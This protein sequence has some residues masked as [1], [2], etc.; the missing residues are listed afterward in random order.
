MIMIVIY[1]FMLLLITFA[2]LALINHYNY[3]SFN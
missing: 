2:E 1:N 3:L